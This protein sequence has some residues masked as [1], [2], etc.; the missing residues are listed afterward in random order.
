MIELQNVAYLRLQMQLER[1][2]LEMDHLR[3]E[4]LKLEHAITAANERCKTLE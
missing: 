1:Q 3:A 4:K 2:H